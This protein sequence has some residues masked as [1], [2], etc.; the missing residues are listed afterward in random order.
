LR[1][2]WLGLAPYSEQTRAYFHGREREQRIV[3]ANLGA[4][5]LTV[6]YGSSG[7]GKSSLLEAGVVPVLREKRAVLLFK[8]WQEAGFLDA[9][10]ERC[11]EAAADVGTQLDPAQP[12]DDL[13]AAT[14]RASG[15]PV[16]VVFDQFEEYF[17]AHA[18]AANGSGFEPELARA[19]NRRDV[20]ASF[21]ISLREDSLAGMDRFQLRI[22]N[23]LGNLIRLEH[24]TMETAERAIRESLAE[25]NREQGADARI[26]DELLREL[27]L[28]VRVQEHASLVTATPSAR[29]DAVDAPLLQLV[30]ARLWD[31]EATD[32]GPS[33][34]L[35]LARYRELGSAEGIVA[36]HFDAILG[37]LTEAQRELCARFFDRLVTPS[38]GKI[39]YPLEDLSKIAGELTPE[40]APTLRALEEA[41]ILQEVGPPGHKA[42]EIY[43]DVLAKTILDWQAEILRERERVEERRRLR[44]RL[45]RFGLIALVLLALAGYVAY[46]SWRAGRPWATV[47]DVGSGHVFQL[48]GAQDVVG[49][50]VPGQPADVSF[51]DRSVSRVHLIVYKDGRSIDPRSTNGTTVDGTFLKYGLGWRKLAPGDVLVLGGAV[52]LRYERIHYP[53]WHVW[54]P[55]AAQRDRAPGW[56]LLVAG[57]HVTPLVGQPQYLRVS[58]GEVVASTSSAGALALTRPETGGAVVADVPDG[59]VTLAQCPATNGERYPLYRLRDGGVN[60]VPANCVLILLGHRAQIV[61]G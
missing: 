42:V 36:E 35:R 28:D 9:L 43:H 23:L 24:L 33:P 37:S 4:R 25:W 53:F 41:R 6:L 3:A 57:R 49:R 11:V 58:G 1:S 40:V 55:G 22:P 45:V 7:V 14:A 50:S 60:S 32:G 46:T 48:K 16:L 18:A 17:V 26:E 51:P 61:A 47:A 39:A 21:L 34:V 13:L 12:L 27:L 2:P 5:R 10:K 54:T 29:D 20:N 38:G 15:A 30:L 56:G 52:V 44:R 19:V 31:R 59:R 8:Q